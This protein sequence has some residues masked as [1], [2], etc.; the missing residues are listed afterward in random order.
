MEIIRRCWAEIDLDALKM[1][2][3]ALRQKTAPGVQMMGVVKADAYGHGA[4]RCAALLAELGMDWFA[5]SNLSEAMQ[6]RRGGI[7]Q[8]ILVLGYTPTDCIGRLTEHRITQTVFSREYLQALTQ[9]AQEAGVTAEIHLKVDTGMGRIG[10]SPEDEA[11][12]A[13]MA[14]LNRNSALR[15]TGIFTHFAVADENGAGEAYTQAQFERFTALCGRL[16]AA[17]L[18]IGLRHCCNSAGIIRYPAMHLDMVRAGVSLYG[19]L[20]SGDC[21][22]QIE[23]HPVMRWQTVISMVKEIAAGQSVSYGR[24]FTAPQPMRVATLSV[25]YADGYSR[26]YSGRGSVLIHGQEAPILG[27]ICMDQCVV[28]VTHIPQ[29]AMGDRVTL[30]GQD[31]AGC[32]SFDRLAALSDTIN[33]ELVCLVGKRVDRIYLSQGRVVAADGLQ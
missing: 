10:F 28:D 16:E 21:A 5:V 12:F 11:D 18:N 33:Y 7:T 6:L 22:G 17:G 19:L 31:G 14:A 30:A 9:A 27:R 1:N 26:G 4:V 8:P 15:V 25:G 23:P 24:T 32:I 20:P 29:A 13:A 2:Y 3:I